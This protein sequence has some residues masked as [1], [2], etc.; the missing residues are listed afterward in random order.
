MS[1]IH[2]SNYIQNDSHVDY[3]GIDTS[4]VIFQ[5]ELQK[6]CKLL[7]VPFYFK[8][9]LVSL[10]A[11]AILMRKTQMHNDN[12]NMAS[13]E[14]SQEVKKKKLS[15]QVN[16]SILNQP[17]SKNSNYGTVLNRAA[18]VLR[19]LYIN[20]LRTLQTNVN[21]LIVQAQALTAYPKTDTKIGKVGR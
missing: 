11:V 5:Q 14:H 17:F 3:S 9:P 8:D 13:R 20:D 7:N 16:E 21:S 12:N 4:S 6:L 18:N 19:L 1:R 10:R 15:S 2:V